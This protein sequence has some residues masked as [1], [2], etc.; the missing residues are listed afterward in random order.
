MIP[1][2]QR[3]M[4][5]ILHYD[6]FE[7][8]CVE[9]LTKIIFINKYSYFFFLFISDGVLGKGFQW[10]HWLLKIKAMVLK[11]NKKHFTNWCLVYKLCVKTLNEGLWNNYFVKHVYYTINCNCAIQIWSLHAHEWKMHSKVTIAIIIGILGE[12]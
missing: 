5:V 10:L 11:S 2:L 6:L 3:G 12:E 7:P 9:Y 8:K 1:K 4:V